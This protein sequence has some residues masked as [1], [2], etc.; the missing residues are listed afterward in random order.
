MD[1]IASAY[2][3][4]SINAVLDIVV[5]TLPIPRLFK[6]NVALRQKV[7]YV[8]SRSACVVILL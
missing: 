4:G 3:V 2:A 7:G 5:I 8:I 1:R 6:L